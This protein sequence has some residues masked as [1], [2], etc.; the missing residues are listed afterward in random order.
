MSDKVRGAAVAGQFYSD[1]GD[2]LGREVDGLLNAAA[3]PDEPAPKAIIAP[4][5]G[6]MFSGGVAV[7]GSARPAAGSAAW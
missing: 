6:F 5:A 2:A 4:H 1:R 3:T 7:P